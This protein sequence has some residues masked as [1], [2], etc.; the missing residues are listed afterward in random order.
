[1]QLARSTNARSRLW[2]L[3]VFS[4]WFIRDH[5]FLLLFAAVAV[6]L[7]LFRY[8]LSSQQHLMSY[9]AMSWGLAALLAILVQTI[10]WW[11][12]HFLLLLFPVA[13][14]AAIGL[15]ALICRAGVKYR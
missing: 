6:L 4:E 15:T 9:G 8:S 12:Y 13:L 11:H 2:L 1:L 3:R 7:I 5:A 10:S 14:L